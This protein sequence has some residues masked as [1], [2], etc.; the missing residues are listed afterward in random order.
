[1]FAALMKQLNV[2]PSTKEASC[3]RQVLQNGCG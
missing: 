2:S 3:V 1:L